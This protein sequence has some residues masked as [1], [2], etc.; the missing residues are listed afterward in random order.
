M[1]PGSAKGITAYERGGST[2]KAVVTA[3]PPG[4]RPAQTMGEAASIAQ[5]KGVRSSK[6]WVTPR[7]RWLIPWTA[8]TSAWVPSR[9][10]T[11]TRAKLRPSCSAQRLAEGRIDLVGLP[12]VLI[13]PE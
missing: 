3:A 13:L 8:T 1:A 4:E 12:G 11:A 2:P 7:A 9:A 6:D 5:R 10:N